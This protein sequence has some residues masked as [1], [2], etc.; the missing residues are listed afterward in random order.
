MRPRGGASPLTQLIEP[1]AE[2]LSS[3]RECHSNPRS[4]DSSP[5][6]VQ[7]LGNS[8]HCAK[9]TAGVIGRF[10]EHAPW[11]GWVKRPTGRAR[12]AIADRVIE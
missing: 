1:L 2:P 9:L 3:N 11:E 6:L 8:A 10:R 7:R 12:D 4:E 5:A